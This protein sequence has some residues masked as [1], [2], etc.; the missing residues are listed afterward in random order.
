VAHSY[1]F[2]YGSAMSVE[3]ANRTLC[4][5]SAS[6]VNMSVVRLRDYTRVWHY[7]ASVMFNDA[8]EHVIDLAFLDLQ[9]QLGASCNGVLIEVT[10]DELARFDIRETGYDRVDVSEGVSD[11]PESGRVFAYIGSSPSMDRLKTAVIASQYERMVQDAAR[12]I[13]DEFL[14][15]FIETTMTSDLPRRDGGYQFANPEQ[16]KAAG[17]DKL[18]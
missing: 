15:E 18:S 8:P 1:I 13:G 16:N 12:H 6:E 17:R 5:E 4:R 3:S 7:L 14:A 11:L 2:G 10:D 9:P